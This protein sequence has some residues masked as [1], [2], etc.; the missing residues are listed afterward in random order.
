MT[1]IQA[2]EF[3]PKLLVDFYESRINL[4]KAPDQPMQSQPSLPPPN[5]AK[6]PTKVEQEC[7]QVPTKLPKAQADTKAGP[8]KLSKKA[9]AALKKE[10]D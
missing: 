10:E 8:K 1:N 2:R 7:A 6:I 9:Q 4:K 5:P 3:C